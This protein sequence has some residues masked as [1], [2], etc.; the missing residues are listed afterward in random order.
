[1]IHPISHGLCP[2]FTFSLPPVVAVKCGPPREIT[3]QVVKQ[4]FSL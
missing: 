1:M 2:Y 3:L 4:A